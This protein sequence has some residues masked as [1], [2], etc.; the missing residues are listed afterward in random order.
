M[1]GTAVETPAPKGDAAAKWMRWLASG[2]G[3]TIA[4]LWV[5]IGGLHGIGD[6]ESWTWEST[7]ISMLVAAAALGVLIGWWKE[8][9]D[10]VVLVTVVT[11]FCAF[12]WVSAGHY[13]G[14]AMLISG[15]PFLVAGILFLGS[16]RRTA[17]RAATGKDHHTG[18]DGRVH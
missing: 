1:G 14:F 3:S 7:A 16:W 10:G 12:A 6:S 13:K 4:G 15:G 8:A 18:N 5:L 11:V 17:T 2:I 9:I